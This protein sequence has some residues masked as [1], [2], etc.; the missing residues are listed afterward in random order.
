MTNGLIIECKMTPLSTLYGVIFNDEIFNPL[1]L[2]PEAWIP[3]SNPICPSLE[4][5]S[6]FFSRDT[7]FLHFDL[8][9]KLNQ[10]SKEN[11]SKWSCVFD[12]E[13]STQIATSAEM[14]EQSH[15]VCNAPWKSDDD[16]RAQ[17][18]GSKLLACIV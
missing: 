7:N 3:K 8:K 5:R 12:S 4:P 10:K 11:A 6:K 15:V 17:S 1:Q 2:D 18:Q 9:L 14:K 16:F 13:N